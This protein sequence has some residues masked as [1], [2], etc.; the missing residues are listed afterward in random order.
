VDHSYKNEFILETF[1]TNK[2]EDDQ[3]SFENQETT[4]K[5]VVEVM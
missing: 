3:F 4:L 2:N 5:K 1:G